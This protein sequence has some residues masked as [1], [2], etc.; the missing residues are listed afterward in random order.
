MFSFI[1][2]FQGTLILV[3]ALLV[4]AVSYATFF[5]WKGRNDNERANEIQNQKSITGADKGE[6]SYRSCHTGWVYDFGSEKCI[7][8]K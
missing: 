6:L 2:K 5:Y 4:G 8:P 7:K 3:A 1:T